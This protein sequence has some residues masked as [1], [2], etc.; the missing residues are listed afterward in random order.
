MHLA[1]LE[2]GESC[3]GAV[4]GF[5]RDPA[6]GVCDNLSRQPRDM[7]TQGGMT[8]FDKL[9]TW[10]FF[11]SNTCNLLRGPLVQPLLLLH[12]VKIHALLNFNQGSRSARLSPQSMTIRRV[13]VQQCASSDSVKVDIP[14]EKAVC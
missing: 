5:K 12:C 1:S 4:I 9:V 2:V 7:I 3:H 10:S 8:F 13:H 6:L 11:L 14:V